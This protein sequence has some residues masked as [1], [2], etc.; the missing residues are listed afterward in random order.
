VAE[1]I[2]N[3]PVY[4]DYPIEEFRDN[5]LIA[6]L[7]LPPKDFEEASLRLFRFPKFKESERDLDSTFRALLPAR[8]TQFFVA[9]RHHVEIFRHV[10]RQI[11]GGYS[12]RNPMTQDGQQ[13]LHN[14]GTPGSRIGP[15][16]P[17]KISFVTG[18]SGQGKSALMRAIMPAVGPAVIQHS[19]F[20][21]KTF[22]ETQI[23]Y[24]MRN[25]PDQCG[26]K[27]LAKVFGDHADEMLQKNLYGR[28]FS[29]R[30]MTRTD[31]VS[32]LR[33]IVAN[34]HVGVLIL[35][36]FQNLSLAGT[37]GQQELIALLVNIRDE[38]GVPIILVGTYKAADVLAGNACTARRLVEG[39]FHELKRPMSAEDED[40]RVF[41][42]IAWNYQWVRNPM[43]LSEDIL[44][45]LYECSQGITGIMLTVFIAA[46][47]EAIDSGEEKVDADLLRKVYC[48]RFEPLHNIIDALRRNEQAFL[49]RYDDLYMKAFSQLKEDQLLGRVDVIKNQMTRAHENQLGID[50]LTDRGKRI[51]SRPDKMAGELA[52]NVLSASTALP[53]VLTSSLVRRVV[54]R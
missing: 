38:L 29:D 23:L 41:C 16:N 5:P 30:S 17:S 6:C 24:L 2:D 53:D 28:M 52:A 34:H 49:N 31:Y 27:A 1:W 8:L 13:L 14:A 36:E 50:L 33:K 3:S 44:A 51:P 12:V 40:W 26:P 39:G 35:D 15:V 7:K 22:T 4:H 18:L 37:V 20:R 21:E 47:I 25:V 43:D 9:N 19:N 45:V 46:Q 42:E 54:E 11:L 48:R 10:Q 32:T